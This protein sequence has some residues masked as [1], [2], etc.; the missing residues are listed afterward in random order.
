[1]HQVAKVL[2]PQL[3]HQ[4][5]Q[6]I[7]RIGS[8]RIDWFDLLAV[9]TTLKSLL[10]HHSLKASILWC[11]AFFIVQLSYL[12]MTTGKTIALTIGKV[13]SLR[14]CLGLT[15]LFFQGAAF[16][17]FMAAVTV[18]SDFGVQENK[19]CHSFHCFPIYLP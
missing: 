11:S 5:I 19:V 12:Y 10:Q 15:L 18:H 17:N 7:F 14:F 8:F 2:E 9:H 1:M 4:Y 6:R 3:Q 16:F 13:M